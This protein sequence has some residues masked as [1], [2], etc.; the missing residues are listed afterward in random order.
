[1]RVRRLTIAVLCVGIVA[2]GPVRAAPRDRVSEIVPT[3]TEAW[4]EPGFRI[5][6]RFGTES[7]V[8]TDPVFARF[9]TDR[10]HFSVAV[11]PGVRLNRWWSVAGAFRYTILTD[12]VGLRWTGTADVNFH[13]FHGLQVGTGV[14][15]GG[16]LGKLCEGSGVAF[17][18][19]TAW[20][21]P[22]GTVFAMGPAIQMDWQTTSC[23]GER[24]PL[25]FQHR[26]V[27]FSWVLAWR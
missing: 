11:E 6:L 5:Q 18:T 10:R 27:N 24:S 22:M 4:E 20:L 15:Y 23:E 17:L 16:M 3:A 13:P 1:M 21:L 12:G 14:G 2:T 19:R 26:S 7:M 9:A 8:P 25:E